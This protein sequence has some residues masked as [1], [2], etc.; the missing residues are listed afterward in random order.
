MF[1]LKKIPYIPKHI[2]KVKLYE[3]LYGIAEDIFWFKPNTERVYHAVKNEPT[4]FL[5]L[6]KSYNLKKNLKKKTLRPDFL[7]SNETGKKCLSQLQP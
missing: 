2:E 3:S 7:T 5:S 6:L 4:K 1:N